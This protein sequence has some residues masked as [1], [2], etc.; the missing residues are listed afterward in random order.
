VIK[1]SVTVKFRITT[2]DLNRAKMLAAMYADGNLSEWIR[3]AVLE[4]P[5]KVLRR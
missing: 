2:K 5:R 1:K 3:F 4:A